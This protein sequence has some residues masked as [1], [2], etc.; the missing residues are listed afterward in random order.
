MYKLS[1]NGDNIIFID[2]DGP[3]LPARMHFA[4][5]NCNIVKS[6]VDIEST[7]QDDH[8]KKRQIRFDPAIMNILN[9]L[10]EKADAKYVLSTNWTKYGT[11]G[12]LQEILTL[13]G[14]LHAYSAIHE[15]WKT[16]K[17]KHWSRGD[18]ISYW[19]SNH[20]NEVKG[21]LILDDDH[22]VLNHPHLDSKRV[23]LA[24]FF[25]GVQWAQFFECF[26][27]FGITDYK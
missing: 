3:L 7:W 19:M 25:E 24:D 5:P 1:L 17:H 6:E 12:E 18:E 4:F 10:V 11:M 14:F 22:S 9:Q 23:V 16:V 21:Y 26:E 20:R 8:Q 2:F 13:N 15:D 27:I